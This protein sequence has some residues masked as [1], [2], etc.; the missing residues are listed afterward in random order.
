ML[1]FSLACCVIV[2]LA[3]TQSKKCPKL[4][5]IPDSRP[6]GVCRNSSLN[7]IG[8]HLDRYLAPYI[9]LLGATLGWLVPHKLFCYGLWE[10]LAWNRKQ[11]DWREGEKS[12]KL[13]K[14][15]WEETFEKLQTA[16]FNL[17]KIALT[18]RIVLHTARKTAKMLLPIA[19]WDWF[20]AKMQILAVL[21]LIKTAFELDIITLTSHFPGTFQLRVVISL[22]LPR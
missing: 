17:K 3:Q 15:E 16:P 6:E 11:E 8:V 20:C 5:N 1:Y 19:E 4:K 14:D 18:R 22:S 12:Y 9:R 10:L 7:L 21:H 2:I 13:R